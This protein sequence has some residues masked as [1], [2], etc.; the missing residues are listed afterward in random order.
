[1]HFLAL[2]LGEVAGVSKPRAGILHR[3]I[4]HSLEKIVT[5]IVMAFSDDWGSVAI[6]KVQQM[7]R[8]NRQRRMKIQ[9]NALIKPRTECAAAHLIEG[10]TVPPAVHVG[11]AQ[12]ES[13]A[14]QDTTKKALIVNVKIPGAVSV[15]KNIR[16]SE[17]TLNC[18]LRQA[19]A[20]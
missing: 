4:E 18:R 8:Q 2:R 16:R 17:K 9:L 7:R 20:R 3:G 1:M 10:A 15:K 19:R 14:S 13:S 12:P 11:L 5:D 6:L